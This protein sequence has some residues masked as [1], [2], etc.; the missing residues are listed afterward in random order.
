MHINLLLDGHVGPL[1]QFISNLCILDIY[2][3]SCE[4]LMWDIKQCNCL[5]AK[6]NEDG[7]G[8]QKGNS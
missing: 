1:L 2:K 4:P 8:L 7:D 3:I 6:R 5:L